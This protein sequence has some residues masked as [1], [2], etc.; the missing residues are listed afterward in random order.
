[1]IPKIVHYVWIG[2]SKPDAVRKNIDAWKRLLPEYSFREWNTTNWDIA[3]NKFAKYFYDKK[4]FGFVGDPIRVDVLKRMGG[5]YLDT[6]VEVYKPF[7]RLLREKLVFSRIYNNALRTATILAEKN[8]EMMRDLVEI[9][10]EFPLTN[11]QDKTVDK[12]N[13]GIFT[14][15]LLSQHLG[16]SFGNSKQRLK[17][18]ALILPKQYF[19]VPAMW[20]ET[21]TFATHHAVGSW[22]DKQERMGELTHGIKAGVKDFIRP[23]FPAII[24]RYDNYKAGKSNSIAREF[25]SKAPK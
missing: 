6:D 2:G 1:M 7:D 4:R 18:G 22:Q 19:E 23:M 24:S 5:I 25:G 11:L 20:F 12:V 10:N 14:R 3:N 17:N 15:Y 16:F 21:G 9:Y 13:N 8:N